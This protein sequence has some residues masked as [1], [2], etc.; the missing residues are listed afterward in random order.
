VASSSSGCHRNLFDYRLECLRGRE[1]F[2]LVEDTVATLQKQQTDT[3]E[4]EKHVLIELVDIK[5][6]L[7]KVLDQ[8]AEVR[9]KMGIKED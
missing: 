4:T 9:R 6:V 5:L 7:Q 1:R 8:E 3:A 2:W